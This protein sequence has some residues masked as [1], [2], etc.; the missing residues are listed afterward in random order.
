MH[1][2]SYTNHSQKTPREDHLIDTYIILLKINNPRRK[3]DV[4]TQWGVF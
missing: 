4:I 1:T 3:N 2:I